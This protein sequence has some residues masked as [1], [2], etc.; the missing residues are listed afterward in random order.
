VILRVRSAVRIMLGSLEEPSI[1]QW[2]DRHLVPRGARGAGTGG[3][4]VT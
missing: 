4:G 2:R 3:G 1:P